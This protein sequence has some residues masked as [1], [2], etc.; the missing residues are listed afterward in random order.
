MNRTSWLGILQ[1][2]SFLRHGRR[3]IETPE[4]PDYEVFKVIVVSIVNECN[5]D[6]LRNRGFLRL[7][8]S[9]DES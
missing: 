6:W 3:L 1:W 5:N 2:R 9:P 7:R 4:Y 8:V